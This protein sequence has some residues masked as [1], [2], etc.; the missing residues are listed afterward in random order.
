MNP[1]TS[2]YS[3]TAAILNALQAS[4]Q[5]VQFTPPGGAA[6][7]AFG[8]VQLFDSEN[9][10]EAFQYLMIVEQRVCV[11]VPLDERIEIIA[12][13]QKLMVRRRRPVAL[14][15]SDRVIGNRKTALWGD[16]KTP[17]AMG[18]ME[19]TLPAVCGQLIDNPN[20]VVSEPSQVSMLTVNDVAKKLPGRL[21]VVLELNC[22]GG[23]LEAATNVVP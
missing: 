10:A 20:G 9:L 5:A 22:V 11:I 12:S 18:L 2:F 3:T 4:V 6:Q 14:L 17:G 13:G 8:N 16:D 1:A 21:A 7:S 15:I 23:R 19:L